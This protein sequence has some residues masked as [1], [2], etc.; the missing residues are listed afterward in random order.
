MNYL[1]CE[2]CKAIS[3]NGACPLCGKKKKLREIIEGETVYL[4]SCE[5]I[6]S[7]TVEDIL[8]DANIKFYCHGILG[9]GVIVSIGEMSELYRYYV[10]FSDYEK[11]KALIPDFSEEVMSE[12]ELNA[13]I[14]SECN[15]ENFSE[16]M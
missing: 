2:K 13:Y 3:E 12:D 6:W 16:E 10:P 9:S 8:N 14:D 4:T 7:K 1:I 15:N 5:Y 11:A